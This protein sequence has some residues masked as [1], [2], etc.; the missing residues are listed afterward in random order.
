MGEP[1]K[2]LLLEKVVEVV[3]RDKLVEN[4]KAIGNSL[5]DGLKEM[6]KQFPNLVYFP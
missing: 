4:T 3:K 5:L 1:T 6:E 2:L